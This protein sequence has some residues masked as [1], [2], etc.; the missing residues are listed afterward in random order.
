VRYFFDFFSLRHFF[1]PGG[2]FVSR[3]IPRGMFDDI[4]HT[5]RYK[6]LFHTSRYDL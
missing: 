3:F 1:I 4:F 2:I 5:S 6:S